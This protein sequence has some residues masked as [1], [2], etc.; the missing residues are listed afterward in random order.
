MKGRHKHILKIL[1]HKLLTAI[2]ILCLIFLTCKVMTNN[3]DGRRQIVDENGGEEVN[4][5][6]NIP[7]DEEMEDF[8]NE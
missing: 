3:T 2:V 6:I 7:E 5:L 4:L 1:F 8:V